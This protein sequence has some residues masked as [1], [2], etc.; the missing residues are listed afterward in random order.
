MSAMHRLG[1]RF[2]NWR[3]RSATEDAERVLFTAD[4]LVGGDYQSQCGQDKWLVER[5][6]PGLKD[7]FFV[8]IGAHDGITFS[9]T[10]FLESRMGWSGIAIEPMPEVYERL[11]KNRRCTTVNACVSATAGHLRF[12]QIS[13][14]SEMLSGLVDQYDARHL[15]RI[16]REVLAHGGSWADI[17]VVSVKLTDLLRENEV[18]TVHYLNIDVEGAELDILRSIDFSVTN[19]LICGI[20]NNYSDYRIPAYMKSVGYK[21]I[22]VVGDEM[23]VRADVS[24]S[25]VIAR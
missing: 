14:Y 19:I 12:R 23:Y 9:N 5:G 20:E 21:L 10:Y 4:E 13:G 25:P 2:N 22:A 18:E 24:L 7:G 15:D 6:F 8:D 11:R 1:Q 17:D 3:Y 16:E